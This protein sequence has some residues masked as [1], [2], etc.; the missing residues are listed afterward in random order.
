MFTTP[1]HTPQTSFAISSPLSYPCPREWRKVAESGGTW[2][3]INF[4]IFFFSKKI[5]K[6]Q[7]FS[8]LSSKFKNI[9]SRVYAHSKRFIE[10]IPRFTELNV[11]FQAHF[12]QCDQPPNSR[13]FCL[14]FP[15]N[16]R[17]LSIFEGPKNREVGGISVLTYLTNSK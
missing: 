13:F 12:R 5:E 14:N 4:Y 1:Y 9:T 7:Y 11:Y 2:S 10:T 3:K 17:F 16:S 6:S 15:P 8:N